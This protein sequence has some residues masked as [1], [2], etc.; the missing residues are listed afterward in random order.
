M[1]K[2]Q[3]IYA[4]QFGLVYDIFCIHSNLD[5]CNSKRIGNTSNP[6]PRYSRFLLLTP[7]SPEEENNLNIHLGEEH[8]TIDR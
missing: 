4:T 1:I 7:Y 8:D 5:W 6:S 3:L 2:F